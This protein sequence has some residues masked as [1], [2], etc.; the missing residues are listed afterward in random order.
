MPTTLQSLSSALTTPLKGFLAYLRVEAG[1]SKSTLEAYERDLCMLIED[2]QQCGRTT[3]ADADPR[4]LAAHLKTLN[5]THGLQPSS[6]ARHLSA[7]RMF[8]R[9]LEANGH[10]SSDPA[11]PLV[12]PTRWKRMPGVLSPS[13]MRALIEAANETAGR[14]WMRDRAM[15]ELMYAAGLR[16]SE[17]GSLRR[18][19]WKKDLAVLLVTGKGDKQRLVPVGKPAIAA[20]ERYLDDQFPN[21]TRFQDGRDQGALVLSHTGRPLTRVAVWQIVR[22]Y[23]ER[24]GL[25]SVHPHMLRHSFATHLLQGGADLRVVQE[26]LG[27]SNIGTTQ[28]YTHVDSR[29]LRDVVM[30]FLPREQRKTA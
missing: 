2:L 7:I 8:F 29:H 19:G 16:A 17:V 10:V 14:L 24:A 27:H 18:D 22:K 23:A 9:W 3:Y 21:L 28:I 15:L 13:R 20:V 11:A 30:K 25:E 6:I 5:T 1:L 26:L 4:D 12:P